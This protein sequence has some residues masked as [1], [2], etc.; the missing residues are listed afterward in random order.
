MTFVPSFLWII[1]GAPHVERLKNRPALSGAL[2]T[3]TAAIVGVILNLGIW[4]GTYTLF[5]TVREREVLGGRLLDP[6]WSSVDWLGVGIAVAA[7]LALFRWNIRILHVVLGA[8]AVGLLS[9]VV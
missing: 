3:I 5:E 6:V 1:A 2:S 8:A 9:A 7:A 4:F